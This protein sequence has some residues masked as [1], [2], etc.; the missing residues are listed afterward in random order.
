MYLRNLD[1]HGRDTEKNLTCV[2]ARL[3]AR[4]AP[5]S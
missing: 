5:V 2:F 1:K 3:A 4:S